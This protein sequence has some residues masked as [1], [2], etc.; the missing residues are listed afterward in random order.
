MANI[1]AELI[2]KGIKTIEQVPIQLRAEVE[3]ILTE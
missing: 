3:K 1:Y 2:R